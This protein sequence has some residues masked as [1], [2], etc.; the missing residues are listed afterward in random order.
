MKIYPTDY[1]AFQ[2]CVNQ[3]TGKGVFYLSFTSPLFLSSTFFLYKLAINLIQIC[4]KKI[5][6][7]S[8]SFPPLTF[9]HLTFGMHFSGGFFWKKILRRR[10]VCKMFIE[11]CPWNQYPWGSKGRRTRVRVKLC[12]MQLWQ[13]L[14]P[15]SGWGQSSGTSMPVQSCSTLPGV[16]GLYTLTSGLVT[17]D[18]GFPGRG[19]SLGQNGLLVLT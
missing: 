10:F 8:F 14:L 4:Y 19:L 15:F 12:V 18:R 2:R 6:K 16:L 17:E 7:G 3:T 13:W 1:T 5:Q 9:T 11:E